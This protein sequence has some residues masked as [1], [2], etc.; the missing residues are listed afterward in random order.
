LAPKVETEETDIAAA[1]TL[2]YEEI[3]KPEGQL[4][5]KTKGAKQ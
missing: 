3:V 1:A 5:K 2:V 4:E